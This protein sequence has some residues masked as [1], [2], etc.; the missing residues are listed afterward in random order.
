MKKLNFIL[1]S[2]ITLTI[3]SSGCKKN[4]D[5]L[6]KEQY[7]K[8]VYL[9]GANKSNNEGRAIIKLNYLNGDEE[10][11]FN[12]SVAAGGSL[13]IDRD[14][15]A[16]IADAGLAP[17][18]AYNS[19]Y[20]YR[21][22]DIK[23]RQLSSSIYRIPNKAVGLKA[24]TTYGTTPVYV[25]TAGLHPDSLYAFTVKVASVSE[26]DY[27]SIRKTDTVLMVSLS[28]I[29]AYSD[30]TYKVEGKTFALSTPTVTTSVSLAARQLKATSSNTVRFFHLD[31]K[32]EYANIALFGVK[33]QVAADNSLTFS[34]WDS[35]VI[36]ASGGTYNPLTKKFTGWYNY[37]S[38][39]I[40]YQFNG[41]FTAT[42][43]PTT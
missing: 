37:V 9:V 42:V 3:L 27:I 32:E 12:L 29:N 33:M 31:N 26:P 21:S 41:T 36:T 4:D 18:T 20:L 2:F 13:N 5:P 34:A 25:K 19:L 22:T 40:T 11:S 16:N 35:L 24:G 38:G 14:I 15:I 28:L 39:G 1:C 10:A 6:D 17:I 7:K 43:P 23:Y 8:Q 30:Y